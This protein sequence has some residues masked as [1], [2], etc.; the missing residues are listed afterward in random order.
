M[1]AVQSELLAPTGCRE[2]RFAEQ[3][4]NYPARYS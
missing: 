1:L 4:F 2:E 3:A